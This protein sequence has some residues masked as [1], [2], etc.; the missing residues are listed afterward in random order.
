MTYQH[1]ED[2]TCDDIGVSA[3]SGAKA[4]D[5]ARILMTNYSRNALP[6]P[7]P[8]KVEVEIMIQDIS[9]ISAITG[10]FT[11][12]YWISAIWNDKR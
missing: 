3:S 12:D 10:T 6:E 4:T 2:F 1:I 7:A 5:L 8:V 11:I 9:D